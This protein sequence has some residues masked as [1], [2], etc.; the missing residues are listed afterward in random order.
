[1]QSHKKLNPLLEEVITR[2]DG[3]T[4]ATKDASFKVSIIMKH[5]CLLFGNALNPSF[6][7]R[8]YH[9]APFALHVRHQR[10]DQKVTDYIISRRRLLNRGR[11]TVG[12]IQLECGCRICG[13]LR[14]YWIPSAQGA[15]QCPALHA[16]SGSRA[17]LGHDEGH[18]SVLLQLLSYLWRASRL[19]R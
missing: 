9:G 16:A 8:I 1:M 15:A 6:P 13:I 11:D 17:E 5:V 3:A 14:V 4:C 18:K 19:S 2:A 7:F 12:N 10:G